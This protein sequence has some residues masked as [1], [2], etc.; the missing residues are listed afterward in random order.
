MISNRWLTLTTIL[1]FSFI[2]LTT[3]HVAAQDRAVDLEV[4]IVE[5]TQD[6]HIELY[7]E[8]GSEE[9]AAEFFFVRGTL[10]NA[11]VFTNPSP[12]AA[13]TIT[14]NTTP[15]R[16]I[17]AQGNAGSGF[18]YDAFDED[19][20]EGE[21][22][23]YMLVE[24]KFNDEVAHDLNNIRCATVGDLA[25]SELTVTDSTKNGD[26]GAMITHTVFITND[27]NRD[28]QF[29]IT[30]PNKVWETQVTSP[31]VFIPS[32]IGIATT[33][34]VMIPAD[35]ADGASDSAEILITRQDNEGEPPNLPPYS[36][37]T[38]VTTKVGDGEDDKFFIYLPLIRT[39]N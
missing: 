35:A 23:C 30:V 13:I 29:I 22:Y 25:F 1:A 10:P 31:I 21:Q 18:I 34:K 6:G 32:G 16:F 15:T 36:V 28:Q 12:N 2:L 4:F 20:V 37:T 33:V 24:R 27:G 14:Y 19:V 7:F 11:P 8:T 9:S 39:E 17:T 3:L 5:P 26:A 38:T